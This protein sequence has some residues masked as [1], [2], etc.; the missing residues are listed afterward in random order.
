MSEFNESKF[1]LCVQVKNPEWAKFPKRIVFSV[2]TKNCLWSNSSEIVL[3][4]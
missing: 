1:I 3:D 2:K 4:H